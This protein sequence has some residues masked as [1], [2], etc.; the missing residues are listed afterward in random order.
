MK[1]LRDIE[2]VIAA[3][4][5]DVLAATAQAL[6]DSAKP[7]KAVGDNVAEAKAEMKEASEV[8]I[9]AKLE[10]FYGAQEFGDGTYREPIGLIPGLPLNN[11]PRGASQ[12]DG[13]TL[14]GAAIMTPTEQAAATVAD[15]RGPFDTDPNTG[16]CLR[17]HGGSRALQV[18][19][20]RTGGV[21][22]R[23]R[24]APRG[25]SPAQPV[26]QR[27][28]RARRAGED[29]R[30]RLAVRQGGQGARRSRRSPRPYR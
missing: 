22:D 7:A 15:P 21:L 4:D 14:P 27:G 28:R 23:G 6:Q 3:F 29:V 19:A 5:R 12:P 30:P 8:S 10:A 16:R 18:R 9:R 25:R 24:P 2:V 26:H 20:P 13:A 11:D 17:D 1:D